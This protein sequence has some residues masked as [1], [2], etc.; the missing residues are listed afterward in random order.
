MRAIRVGRFRVFEGICAI[1]ILLCGTQTHAPAQTTPEP[2]AFEVATIKP[3]A[4][5]AKNGDFGVHIGLTRASYISMN[6]QALFAYAYGFGYFQ[7]SGPKWVSTLTD[8][9]DVVGILPE[10]ASQ[11]SE[12]KRLQTLLSDRFQLRFHVEKREE[13][14]YALVIG[15]DGAKLK[16]SIA[17]ELEDTT[18]LRPGEQIFGYGRNKD[19][20]LATS[21]MDAKVMHTES[22]RMS[23]EYLAKAL[24]SMLNETGGKDIVVDRTGL[25]GN[26]QVTLDRPM[27][28]MEQ[29]DDS[30][31]ASAPDPVGRGTLK[32]SLDKLGLRLVKQNAQVDYYVIDHV[33]KPSEN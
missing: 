31:G 20:E 3:R 8:L 11:E 14:V 30:S 6:V 25:E 27:L 23:M 16:K 13:K 7:I 24:T 19:R 15:K 32:S 10:G 17:S 2:I 28:A 33:E 18:P 12:R 21:D 5:I 1:A 22:S 4:E 29:S 9:Y 26:Y